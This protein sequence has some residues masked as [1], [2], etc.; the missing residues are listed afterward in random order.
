VLQEE[1][2]TSRV[3][4]VPGPRGAPDESPSDADDMGLDGP[5][6]LAPLLED[7][8]AGDPDTVRLWV[9]TWNMGAGDPLS[10][11]DDTRLPLMLRKFVFPENRRYDIYLMGVQEG[12]TDHLFEAMETAL[13]EAGCSRVHLGDQL[14]YQDPTAD[15]DE[16]GVGKTADKLFGR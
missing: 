2:R 14:Q 7:V 12:V 1:L 5:M 3:M 6:P 11:P 8:G 15:P 4:A 9:G 16:A 10:S 13:E